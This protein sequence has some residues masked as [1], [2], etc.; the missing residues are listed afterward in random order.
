M[1]AY[2]NV[3]KEDGDESP[4]SEIP[5]AGRGNSG[6]GQAWLNPSPNQLHRALVR[7]GKDSSDDT[8]FEVAHVHELVTNQTWEA[9]KE[10]ERTI[11]PECADD[12]RLVRFTGMW[13]QDSFKGWLT[14]RLFGYE[15]Y[16]RHDWTIDRCG[17]EVRYVIDYYMVEDDEITH[18]VDARP[19]PTFGGL[20]DRLKY[21]IKRK[22]EGKKVW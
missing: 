16:D 18:F 11:H 15:P 20:F 5:A 17:E 3:K 2:L 19:A 22:M 9:V 14:K 4:E 21:A 7:K 8:K 1:A 12:L 10:Y 13:G 6:D